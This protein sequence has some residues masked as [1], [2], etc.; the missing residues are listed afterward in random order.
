M[1]ANPQAKVS[2]LLK[3]KELWLLVLFGIALFSSPLFFGK[4]FFIGDLFYYFLPEKKLIGSLIRAGDFPFWNPY[5]YGGQPFLANLNNSVLYPSTLL[6]VVLSPMNA[7]NVDIVLHLI[8]CAVCSYLLA[9]TLGF[10]PFSAFLCGLVFGFS[11]YTLS[12]GNLFNRL[13][14]FP[15]LPLS[16]F[17]WHRAISSGNRKWIIFT[18]FAVT[19]QFFAGAPETSVLTVASIFF[20]SLVY[21]GKRSRKYSVA[22]ALLVCF[23]VLGLS[24]IQMLPTAE[25]FL[26]S[27]RGKFTSYVVFTDYSVHPKRIPELI[28]PGFLGNVADR[29]HF[30]GTNMQDGGSLFVSSIYF[31]ILALFLAAYGALHRGSNEILPAKLRRALFAIFALSLLLSLGRYLPGFVLLFRIPFVSFFRYPVKFLAAGVLPISLLCAAAVEHMFP[32]SNSAKPSGKFLFLCWILFFALV[33]MFFV[34]PA[35]IRFFFG[36][37]NAMIENGVRQSFIHTIAI[38]LLACLS[39]QLFRTKSFPGQRWFLGGI[40]ALDL[41]WAGAAVNPFIERSI[42]FQNYPLVDLVKKEIHEGRLYRPITGSVILNVPSP[43]ISYGIQWD[44]ATLNAYTNAFFEIPLIYN[45]SLESL[46]TSRLLDL[47]LKVSSLPWEARIPFLS[48]GNVNLVITPD[49]LNMRAL[50]SIGKIDTNSNLPFYVYKNVDSV[51]RVKFYTSGAI[52][53]SPSEALAALQHP[54][55]DPQK[56]VVLEGAKR[57]EKSCTESNAVIETISQRSDFR[58]YHVRNSCEGYLYISEP[59]YKGWRVT[60]DG[61]PGSIVPANEAFFAIPLEIGNHLVTIRYL[62]QSFVIGLL[63]SGITFIV[64]MMW[65]AISRRSSSA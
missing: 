46:E 55:F 17:L 15:Y 45:L 65:L 16:L 59:Y 49:Q 2:S 8:L 21:R 36:S 34:F 14:A 63:I 42:F 31:G 47:R 18:V 4:T 23:F 12:H 11:G 54:V 29:S 50:Q 56:Y 38:F 41:L 25:L 62:P 35:C 57:P 60:L 30:W 53:R 51:P 39:F 32:F 19:I 5:L 40:L 26:Q 22:A 61:K 33:G 1:S 58:S 13:L 3:E 44:L 7:F 10:A 64:M 27:P 28:L 20:L 43:E 48:V 24:A 37:S 52:V 9:R 6:Y